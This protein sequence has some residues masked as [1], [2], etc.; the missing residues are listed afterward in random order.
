MSDAD[1]RDARLRMADALERR[2]QHEAREAGALVARFAEQAVEAG[3]PAE[4]LTARA[5]SGS[6]RFRTQVEG[7]YLKRDRSVAVGTDG[8]FYVLAA[9]GGLAERFRGVTLSASDAPLEL[10]RGARDGESMPL[11]EALAARLEAGAAWPG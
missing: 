11:A 3:I 4:R 2:R 6:T 1:D 10:G 5:Y 7:W 9:H 8:L